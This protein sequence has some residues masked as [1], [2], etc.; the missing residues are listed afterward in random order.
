MTEPNPPATPSAPAASPASDGG[1]SMGEI[2]RILNYDPFA[3]PVPGDS[4]ATPE[5]KPEEPAPAAPAPTTGTP[6]PEAQPQPQPEAAPAAA[7]A[8]GTPQAAP[9]EAQ[10]PD[11]RL[12]AILQEVRKIGQR[13][14]AEA[15]GDDLPPYEFDVP[16]QMMTMLN[17]EN[18]AERKAGVQY[19]IKGV[20]RAIHSQIRQ[21][22]RQV[23][24]QVIAAH[25]QRY[26]HQRA[27][28]QDFYETHKDLNRPELRQH[29]QAAAAMLLPSYPEGWSPR[30]RDAIARAVRAAQGLPDPSAP[31]QP[32][33]PP[34]PAPAAPA[35]ASFTPGTRPTAPHLD[36]QQR[37]MMEL[38]AFG[39]GG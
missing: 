12:D 26:E 30:L 24:P 21:E 11:P 4:P 37:E 5:P 29:V 25:I 31:P 14:G 2:E 33:P 7:P 16:E 1:L 17:S 39:P 32:A 38:L 28:F 15:K 23:L 36:A 9:A 27:I 34:A 13:S 22:I 8:P 35:P 19:L 18:P 3:T 10:T 20:G 6:A